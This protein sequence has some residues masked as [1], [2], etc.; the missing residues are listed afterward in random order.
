VLADK[1]VVSDRYGDSVLQM[2]AHGQNPGIQPFAHEGARER[3]RAPVGQHKFPP[4]TILSMESSHVPD[5]GTVVDEKEF[6][7]TLEPCQSFVFIN[8]NRLVREIAA[9][10]DYRE[11]KLS[12]QHVVQGSIGK[13]SRQIGVAGATADETVRREPSCLTLRST[14]G[15]SGALRSLAS[16]GDTAQF[17]SN[18]LN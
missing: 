11:T 13:Q 18:M 14:M 17:S 6:R 2:P 15:D 12:H 16:S 7:D 9:G 5:D 8:A 4:R 10:R 1:N 3:I